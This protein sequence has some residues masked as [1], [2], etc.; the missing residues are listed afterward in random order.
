MKYF[1]VQVIKIARGMDL[2]NTLPSRKPQR[3]CKS[4]EVG[5]YKHWSILFLFFYKSVTIL[6]EPL[7]SKDI[8]V[9]NMSRWIS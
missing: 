4:P 1:V 6:L 8:H 9:V 7:V 3:F 5:E 2:R